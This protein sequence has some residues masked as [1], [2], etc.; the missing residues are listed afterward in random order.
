MSRFARN[1]TFSALAGVSASAGSFLSTIIVARMLGVQLAGDVAFALWIATTLATVSNLGLPAT[2]ARY[3]P[4][5]ESSGK[6][7]EAHGL[8]WWLAKFYV[9]AYGLTILVIG[10]VLWTLRS[11]TLSSTLGLSPEA[12]HEGLG[13]ALIIVCLYTAQLWGQFAAGWLQGFQNFGKIYLVTI[14]SNLIQLMAVALGAHLFG[15]MG[16]LTGY[17]VGAAILVLPLTLLGRNAAPIDAR[18]SKRVLR[19][20]AFAWAAGITNAF[21]WSRVEV[22]FLKNFWSSEQVSYF[23]AALA[24]SNIAAQGPILLTGGL[25]PHFSSLNA[26]SAER[27]AATYAAATRLIAFLVLPAC[28]GAAAVMPMLLPLL[29]GQ[30]FAPAVRAAEILVSASAVGAIG[31][32]SAQ[33]LSGI[34]RSDTI[35]YISFFGMV[36]STISGFTLI[37]LFGIDG[38]AFGRAAIQIAMVLIGI[39]YTGRYARCR[40]PWT[41]VGKLLLCAVVT[42]LAARLVL[43]LWPQPPFLFVAILTGVVTYLVMVRVSGAMPQSDLEWLGR[44]TDKLPAVVKRFAYMTLGFISSH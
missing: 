20:A 28:L 42:A 36:A 30:A 29:Y 5:L 17:A 1:S 16:A 14:S 6:P 25:L 9:A 10:T 33:L 21:V 15:A 12:A 40:F 26:T 23:V 39:V 43:V 34:E 24:I 27:L 22:V 7:I 41:S 8:A 35:F 18:L 31:A 19:Y 11:E 13:Y 32:V 38:A 44:I 37:R 3:L 4:E 2:M